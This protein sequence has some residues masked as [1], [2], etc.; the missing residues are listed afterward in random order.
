VVSPCHTYAETVS[1]TLVEAS[2]TF[3]SR[4]AAPPRSELKSPAVAEGGGV[5]WRVWDWYW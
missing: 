4:L 3:F 5:C 1:M 2:L